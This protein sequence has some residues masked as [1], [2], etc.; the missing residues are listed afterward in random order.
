MTLATQL[1]TAKPGDV[2]ALT[3]PQAPIF[4]K[5]LTFAAPGI[6][7]DLSAATLSN[8]RLQSVQ[9]VTIKGGQFTPTDY[10]GAVYIDRCQHIVVQGI[11]L[12]GQ[13]LWNG[14]TVRASSDVSVLASRFDCPKTGIPA[15]RLTGGLI[16]GNTFYGYAVDGVDLAGCHDVTVEFNG[17]MGGMLADDHHPDAVQGWPLPGEPPPSGNIIRKNLIH[18]HTQGVGFYNHDA[19]GF[20]GH[21][22]EDNDI[23]IS[24]PGAITLGG[25]RTSVVRRNRVRTLPGSDYKAKIVTDAPRSGNTVD[26]Y[27]RWASDNDPA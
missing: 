17:F 26:A 14:V 15:E 22:I 19:G 13:G 8:V 11:S 3:G 4:I 1:A 12:D 16:Q 5:G 25:S 7:L 24:Y 27:L 9:G 21:V 10:L 6:T 18:G 20:D 2:L 23:C